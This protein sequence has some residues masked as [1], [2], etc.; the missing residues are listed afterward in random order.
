MR[1]VLCWFS[2]LL[3]RPGD[4]VAVIL[5]LNPAGCPQPD[6]PFAGAVIGKDSYTAPK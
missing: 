5:E 3:H 1:L 4:G 6:H 2:L